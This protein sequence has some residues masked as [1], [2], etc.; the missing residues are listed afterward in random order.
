MEKIFLTHSEQLDYLVEAKGLAV[1]D[2]TRALDLLCRFGYFALIDGYKAPFKRP[3]GDKYRDGATFDDVV[4]LFKMD[5]NL[6]ELFFK[7]IMRVELQLRSLI[8]YHFTEKHG[9][10]QEKYLDR[11]NYIPGEE[12][13][14]DVFRVISKLRDLCDQR[15]NFDYINHHVE[16]Y[17]NVP[18]WV[19]VNALSLG[20]LVNLYDCQTSDVKEK[21]ADRFGGIAPSELGSLLDLLTK[22]RNVS[23]HNERLYSACADNEICDTPLHEKYRAERRGRHYLSGKRDL[24][25]AAI[26]LETTLPRE[27][28]EKFK[29]GLCAIIEHFFSVSKVIPREEF[30]SIMGFT[31]E[32]FV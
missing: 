26:A 24:F 1:P 16:K 32:Y 4:A 14:R 19:L 31:E 6:R 27:D 2:R 21:I 17:G 13:D 10:R 7:Y 5:E 28:G 25:A 3:D 20:A 23:A 29:R 18:L 9:S 8:S 22:F 11:E 12:H 15:G 30:L